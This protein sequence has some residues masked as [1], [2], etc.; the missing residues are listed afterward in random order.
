MRRFSQDQAAAQEG[1]VSKKRLRS[2]PEAF[3]EGASGCEGAPNARSVTSGTPD[4]SQLPC[5]TLLAGYRDRFLKPKDQAA[6]MPA[7][8]PLAGVRLLWFI[9]ARSAR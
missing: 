8:N 6:A 4:R 2:S 7:G 5:R 1:G 3:P 9:P